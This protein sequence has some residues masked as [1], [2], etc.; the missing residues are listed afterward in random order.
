VYAGIFHGC[1]YW[2]A[3]GD[4]VT[5]NV[6]Y[7][8]PGQVSEAESINVDV[9]IMEIAFERSQGGI[10][11]TKIV[12]R[13]K[14]GAWNK[15]LTKRARLVSA[16]SNKKLTNRSNIV[17]VASSTYTDSADYYCDGTGDDV[18]IQAAIDAVYE[19]G[20]G[21]VHLTNGDFNL[22]TQVQVFSNIILEGESSATILHSERVQI[23]HADNAIIKNLTVA[24][25]TESGLAIGILITDSSISN[26]NSII[27]CVV[28]SVHSTGSQANGI[29]CETRVSP[30]VS[31]A[32]IRDCVIRN[33]VSN[34]GGYV[35]S[36]ILGANMATNN[37]V[38]TVTNTAT[39]ANAAGFDTCKKCQQNRV[40]TA[41]TKYLDSYADSG[42]SNA[43]ADTAAGG[44][45]S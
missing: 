28:D 7:Q 29:F 19:N 21:T 25:I 11:S 10:G 36:G 4:Y 9:E 45:N 20:G 33:I 44:Y 3:V 40:I 8:L 34:N 42:T 16:A 35:S 5:L 15:S 1:L 39:P 24:N 6:S 22:L 18:E 14:I 31:S 43:C 27:N 26:T 41:S 23:Y 38:E 12:M 30:F 2:Y 13:K 17:V 32:I 37:L